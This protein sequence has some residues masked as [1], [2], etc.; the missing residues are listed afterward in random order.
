MEYI[1]RDQDEDRSN[2]S[3]IGQTIHSNKTTTGIT[4]IIS[5]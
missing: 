3:K 4:T 5:N 1:T 2:T